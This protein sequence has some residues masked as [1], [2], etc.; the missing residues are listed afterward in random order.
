MAYQYDAFFSYKRARESDDWHERV[1]T[2]VEYWLGQALNRQDVS[3][4]FDRED[5]R[6]GSRWGQLIADA[7]KRSKC[8]I[9]IWSPLYFQ[10]KYCVSEWRTFVEREQKFN[11]PLIAPASYFDGKTFPPDASRWQTK[12]FSLYASTMPRFWDTESAVWFE[13]RALRPFAED[14][15]AMIEQA[16]SYDDTFPVIEADDDQVQKRETIGRLADV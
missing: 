9:C 2:T 13:K 16:P 4:F 10:S 15:A 6:T 7:L 14:L 8:I 5:I 1:K 3:I 11:K 12:D